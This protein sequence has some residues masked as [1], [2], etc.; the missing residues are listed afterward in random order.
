LAPALEEVRT[1]MESERGLVLLLAAPDHTDAPLTIAAQIG[2]APGFALSGLPQPDGLVR[3]AITQREALT[4]LLQQG[5]AEAGIRAAAIAPLWSGDAILGALVLE[6]TQA[7]AEGF[8]NESLETL[9]CVGY[10]LGLGLQR[11]SAMRALLTQEN[12]AAAGRMLATVALDIQAPATVFRADLGRLK[13]IVLNLAK[14]ALDV[15]GSGGHLCIAFATVPE[16]LRLTVSDDG[17]GIAPQ[18]LPKFFQEFIT[19]GKKGGTG[20]GLA[21]V[22]RFAEDHG[23]SVRCES[24]PGHGAT[25]CVVLPSAPK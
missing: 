1:A 15:L 12:L 10:L 22:K 17:P 24:E 25:F 16:G 21:I 23:G 8:E 14:N 13:R 6:R 20:L 2:H 7:D 11:D 5:E 9:A 3:R 18:I 19:H 4:F